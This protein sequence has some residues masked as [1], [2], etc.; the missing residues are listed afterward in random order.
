L[1]GINHPIRPDERAWP[2]PCA[3]GPEDVAALLRAGL[4]AGR[5][6]RRAQ[7][8]NRL[9][10]ELLRRQPPSFTREVMV[11]LGHQSSRAL[12][13]IL[14]AFLDQDQDQMAEP[15]DL[16]TLLGE[17]LGVPVP[18]QRDFMAGGHKARQS[19]YEALSRLADQIFDEANPYLARKAHLQVMR[20]AVL[21]ALV[22]RPDLA[23]LEE[24]ARLSVVRADEVGGRCSFERDDRGGPRQRA[25]DAYSSAFRACARL[26]ERAPRAFQIPWLH[27]FWLRNEEALRVL[28]VVRSL[29][30]ERRHQEELLADPLV[31]LLIDPPPGKYD[32]SIVSCMGVITDG[33]DGKEL[34]DAWRRLEEQRGV[35]LI[36]AATGTAWSLE[37]NAAKIIEAIASCTTPWGIIG[38]SQGCANALMAESMLY[39]G[40]PE[41]QRLLDTMVCRNMLFSAVNGSAHGT[42]GMIKFLRAL[43]LGERSLKHYQAVYSWE[44]IQAVLRAV[45]A[46]L[47]SRPFVHVLGGAHS[48]SFERARILH[49]DEQFLDHVPTSLTRGVVTDDR[50]PETLE[51]LYY[52]LKELTHGA[53]Q[54]TQ[55]L[56]TDAIG[57]STR[58]INDNT[59]VLARCDMATHPQATH[60]WAPLS[61]EVE[62]V[63]TERDRALAIYDSPK[64][65]LVWPWV[66]VNARFCRI[67]GR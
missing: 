60:H 26:L 42:S 20:H 54:D 35:R 29:Y 33:A 12:A 24:R 46:A 32:F 45:K 49:R 23:E 25:R 62:F 53:E 66:E 1:P 41:Q 47:D 39:G 11:E 14:Y 67:R 21:P 55:V 5:Q 37:R 16:V 59:A 43:V 6:D 2:P 34:I 3:L 48:L 31:R 61:V 57:S 4:A 63:K 64:D 58:V 38:Y 10:L 15:L 30:W 40:T 7:I 8:N 65:R 51:Y 52:V 56:I 13:G 19:Y 17:K 28:S 36:R 9:L 44:A 18:R 27:A 22:V 50:V